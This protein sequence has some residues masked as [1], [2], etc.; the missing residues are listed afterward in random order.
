VLLLLLL[1]NDDDDVVDDYYMVDLFSWTWRV[2]IYG[3]AVPVVSP[4]SGL[5]PY[6]WEILLELNQP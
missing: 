6:T 3:W 1:D 2:A 4:P 5:D